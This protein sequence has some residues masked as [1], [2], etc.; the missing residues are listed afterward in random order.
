[1]RSDRKC[2]VRSRWV[3]TALALIGLGA[4]ACAGNVQGVELPP[5]LGVDTVFVANA[6]EVD[7]R[8]AY[9]TRGKQSTL[10]IGRDGE[11]TYALTAR[12]W[13]TRCAAEWR[14]ARGR[15]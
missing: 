8:V 13:S 5:T 7:P 11:L 4:G 6:G 12:H 9:Y 14:G 10:F 1:M 2:R 15:P 3:G